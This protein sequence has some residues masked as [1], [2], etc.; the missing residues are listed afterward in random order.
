MAPFGCV[1]GAPVEILFYFTE[2]PDEVPAAFQLVRT[3]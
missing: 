2:A 3:K 1:L